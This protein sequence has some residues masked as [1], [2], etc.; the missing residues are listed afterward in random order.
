LIREERQ[1]PHFMEYG[2]KPEQLWIMQQQLYGKAVTPLAQSVQ[3]KRI[4]HNNFL[5]W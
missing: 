1:D 4:K 2:F 5:K 3:N